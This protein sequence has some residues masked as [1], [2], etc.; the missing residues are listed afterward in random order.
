MV[1]TVSNLTWFNNIVS[2]DEK[3]IFSNSLEYTNLQISTMFLNFIRLAD[4][5]FL[6]PVTFVPTN[7][8]VNRLK[9]TIIIIL[10]LLKDVSKIMLILY[11]FLN[12]TSK[13]I[14]EC[15]AWIFFFINISTLTICVS[16]QKI[17]KF[18]K[19]NCHVFNF[20]VCTMQYVSIQ[21]DI[22]S[23]HIKF[24][25]RTSIYL[26]LSWGKAKEFLIRLK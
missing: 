22:N 14:S 10:T 18:V 9:V 1:L 12:Q 11:F 5:R 20:N 13:E 23:R 4:Y 16:N 19:I 26:S 21:C 6:W 15:Q 3:K 17:T 25:L 24:V 8:S 2:K 7:L